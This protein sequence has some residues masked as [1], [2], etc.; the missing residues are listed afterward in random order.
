MDW[1]YSV[2]VHLN[3]FHWYVQNNCAVTK[4]DL[5]IF[6]VC[7]NRSILLFYCTHNMWKFILISV[8][9]PGCIWHT[10]SAETG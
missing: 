6:M 4:L 2:Q 1:V 9:L 7:S 5:F 8:D 10:H 3:I